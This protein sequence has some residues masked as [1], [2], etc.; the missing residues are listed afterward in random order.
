[1]NFHGNHHCHVAVEV[2]QFPC[3]SGGLCQG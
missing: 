3:A 2:K 1:V